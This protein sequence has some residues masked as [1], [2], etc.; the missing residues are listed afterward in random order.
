M[1]DES[2]NGKHES[3]GRKLVV[4][5]VVLA[6]AVFLWFLAGDTLSLERLAEHESSLREFQTEHP[7]LV[8]LVVFAVYVLVTGLSV[9]GAAAMTLIVAWFFGFWKAVVLVS[10]ASTA[11]ATIAFLLSRYL[12]RETIQRRFAGQLVRF[13]EALE[14]EGAFYLFTLRLIPAVPF[15]VINVV[16][17]LTKLRVTTFWW[18]S[19]VGMLAGTCV[20]V[21]AGTTIPSLAQL[22]DPSLVR[23][24]D[25]TD[26]NEF[27]RRLGKAKPG[28]AERHLADRLDRK[29]TGDP[30]HPDSDG[31][32]D[33]TDEQ[34]LELA[35]ALN[36]VLQ[37]KDFVLGEGWKPPSATASGD[38]TETERRQRKQLTAINRAALVYAFPDLILAPQPILSKQLLFAFVLLGVFPLAVRRLMGRI[39][40][41][42]QN[43]P[44]V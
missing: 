19:Q 12:L 40:P 13:N 16:M 27:T 18:V 6:V 32:L 31:G 5:G 1:Q 38:R 10:F 35:R 37:E 28:T 33:L 14:R 4:P 29:L 42:T 39:R 34:K 3:P 23:V 44:S 41:G 26:W 8:V 17:G 30:P 36:Q 21:Y 25:I 7:W 15:F 2:A 24:T 22:A 9:P 43:R 20:Y 11:G